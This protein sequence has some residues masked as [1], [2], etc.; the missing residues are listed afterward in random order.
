[1][2]RK[3]FR[4]MDALS[5]VKSGQ[6]D[7]K[8]EDWSIRVTS[9]SYKSNISGKYIT[10][11]YVTSGYVDSRGYVC[12]PHETRYTLDEWVQTH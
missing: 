11:V 2:N 5:K 1:M 3:N 9:Y 4:K 8:T 6:Y 10:T 7:H 12:Y